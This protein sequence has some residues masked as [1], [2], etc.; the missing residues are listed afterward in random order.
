MRRLASL[1]LLALFASTCA[2]E[3]DVLVQTLG[4]IRTAGGKEVRVA[5]RVN[6]H[7]VVPFAISAEIEF[8]G[9]LDEVRRSADRIGCFIRVM[10]VGRRT[11]LES[12]EEER[13]YTADAIRR[14]PPTECGEMTCRRVVWA[15]KLVATDGATILPVWTGTFDLRAVCGTEHEIG[16]DFDG[17]TVE[18]NVKGP[19]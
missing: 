4:R 3:P 7:Q 11:P 15:R 5:A 14:D 18:G 10:D 8:R 2:R 1:T 6:R 9:D 19:Q 16:A 13:S 12:V 17:I